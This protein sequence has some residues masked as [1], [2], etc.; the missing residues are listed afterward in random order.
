MHNYPAADCSTESAGMAGEA[1]GV[2]SGAGVSGTAL[3]CASVIVMVAPVLMAPTSGP[4]T[5][6]GTEYSGLM[7][8]AEN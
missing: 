5:T 7:Y 4:C 8:F 6:E 1:V 2:V 3:P